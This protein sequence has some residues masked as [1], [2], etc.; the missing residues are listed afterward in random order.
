VGPRRLCRRGGAARPVA[1][2]EAEEAL[3]VAAEE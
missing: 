3:A 1:A 2:T